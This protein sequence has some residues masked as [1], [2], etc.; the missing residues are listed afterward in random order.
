MH[1]TAMDDE[2]SRKLSSDRTA[3][4]K[5]VK[6]CKKEEEEEEKDKTRRT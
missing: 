2:L 4:E 5:L 3:T 1:C 6:L